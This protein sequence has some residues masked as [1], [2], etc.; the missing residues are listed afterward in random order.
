MVMTQGRDQFSKVTWLPSLG[1]GEQK[2]EHCHKSI[3]SKRRVL[4][5]SLSGFLKAARILFQAPWTFSQKVK[6]SA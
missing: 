4:A 6:A 5:S 1:A 2:K 3:S